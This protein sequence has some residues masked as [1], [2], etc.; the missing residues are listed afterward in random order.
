MNELTLDGKKYISS[1][2]AAEITGYAK[3]YVG[4]LAREGYVVATMVGRSWYVLESSINAHRFG[5]EAQELDKSTV[6]HSSDGQINTK[7]IAHN[8]TN[9]VAPIWVPA[10]Y[11]TE[12]VNLI[13][14]IKEKVADVVSTIKIIENNHTSTEMWHDQSVKDEPIAAE[15]PENSLPNMQEAWQEWFAQKNQSLLE[16]EEVMESR[17]AQAIEPIL[18]VKQKQDYAPVATVVSM[19]ETANDTHIS[20]VEPRASDENHMQ[21]SK[22]NVVKNEEVTT[23]ITIQKVRNTVADPNKRSKSNVSILPRTR[24]KNFLVPNALLIGL[25]ITC[26]SIFFIASGYG[27]KYINAS[28]YKKSPIINFL[29]GKSFILR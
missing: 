25:I 29:E 21:E 20:S 6:T 15:S 2:R 26:C 3:D 1:K 18:E 16:S 7:N 19:G 28:V 24:N 9:D 27:E 10:A 23:V 14:P 8:L 17:Y 4:Q 12:E 5:N 13:V 22:T 11:T